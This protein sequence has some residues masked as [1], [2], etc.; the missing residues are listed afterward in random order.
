MADSR[1]LPRSLTI[2]YT[3]DALLLSLLFTG[4]FFGAYSAYNRYLKQYTKVASIPSSAFRRR[5]LYGKV[6][7]VGDGD[8]FHFFHTPGGVLGGWGWLRELPE[9]SKLQVK[10]IQP[11]STKSDDKSPIYNRIF[12]NIFQRNKSQIAW[13]NHFL[14]LQVPYKNRRNLPT[15]SVRICG[16][17]APERAHFGN[18][19]QPFS[20]E[21]LNWLSYTLLGKN[22]WIKPLSVDQY[23][24]C[25]AKVMYW[26]W[27]GWKNI[28]VE[29]VK[30]G[31]AVVYESKGSAEFDG[32]EQIYRKNERI[33]STQKKGIW[34][35]K[36]FETPGEYKKRT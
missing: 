29:M 35:Q 5:W 3:G 26:T 25:V 22:V 1:N 24:R 4:S 32:E 17:D 19:A 9:L 33:A 36:K 31:L 23:S 12:R 15:I 14:S 8:N 13:S 21:A 16:V 30:E 7:S 28:G 34:T 10:D 2:S 20:D 11:K 27:T 18:S 6:T